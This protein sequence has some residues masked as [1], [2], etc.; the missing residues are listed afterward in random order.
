[1]SSSNDTLSTPIADPQRCPDCGRYFTD[2]AVMARHLARTG[3]SVR[4]LSAPEMKEAGMY[5]VSRWHWEP[6]SNGESRAGA[7]EE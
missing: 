2:Q 1:M 7:G 4:C 6:S 3:D 5:R